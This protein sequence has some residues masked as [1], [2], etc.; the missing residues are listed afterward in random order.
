MHFRSAPGDPPS[1]AIKNFRLCQGNVM[2][3]AWLLDVRLKHLWSLSRDE[4]IDHFLQEVGR[5]SHD[6]RRSLSY[7]MGRDG[8]DLSRHGLKTDLCWWGRGL[9]S[10]GSFPENLQKLALVVRNKLISRDPKQLHITT[11]HFLI[12]H[13]QFMSVL[14]VLENYTV[15]KR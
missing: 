8:R 12:L 3:I 10:T 6:S 7:L 11:F 5:A 14:A 13:L 1:Q 15:L 4:L 9:S 2:K